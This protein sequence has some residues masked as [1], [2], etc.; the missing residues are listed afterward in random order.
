MAAVDF[1]IGRQCRDAMIGA[2]RRMT[3]CAGRIKVNV[4]NGFLHEDLIAAAL[5]V[6]DLGDVVTAI[7]KL[8]PRLALNDVQWRAIEIAEARDSS[9]E[10][11]D[12]LP[13]MLVDV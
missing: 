2:A 6:S 13:K 3:G 5:V 12:L 8:A 10:V 9:L 1:E 7:V 11:A 4:G